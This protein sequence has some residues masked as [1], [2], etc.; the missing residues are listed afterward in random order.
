M[1]Q[2]RHLP[3]GSPFSAAG[4]TFQVVCKPTGSTAEAPFDAA[5]LEFVAAFETEG[6]AEMVCSTL[7]DAVAECGQAMKLSEAA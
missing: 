2:V 5:D 1:Y 3:I 4:L 6:V 7:N